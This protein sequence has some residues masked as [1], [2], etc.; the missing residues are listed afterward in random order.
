MNYEIIEKFATSEGIKYI[1]LR[2]I[3]RD[4]IMFTTR[5]PP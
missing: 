3:T 5:F 2:L 4:Y 1:Y